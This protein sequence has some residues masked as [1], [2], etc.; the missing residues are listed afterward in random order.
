MGLPARSRSERSVLRSYCVC[1]TGTIA[2]VGIRSSSVSVKALHASWKWWSS[3]VS[4]GA[5]IEVLVLHQADRRRL[6]G[7][8]DDVEP[9]RV[10]REAIDRG[11]LDVAGKAHCAVGRAVREA[12]RVLGCIGLGRPD[13]APEAFGTAVQHVPAFV[14]RE[15]VGLAVE[16]EARAADAVGDAAGE[17]TEMRR[18]AGIG[19]ELVEAEDHR[20]T[21]PFTGT[22]QSR[23]A[24]P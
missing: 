17:R 19:G 24:T 20:R 18:V 5:E 12:H 4:V 14:R 10:A 11:E 23:T 9:E 16:L 7:A 2:P 13:D 22:R 1:A 8:R 3:T 21:P 15:L 6:V